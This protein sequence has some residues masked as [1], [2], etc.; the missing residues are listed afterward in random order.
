MRIVIVEDEILA[1]EDL[2]Q[3]LLQVLPQ[4]EIVKHVQSVEEGLVFFGS[5][6]KIDLIFSDIQLGDG[7]S[8]Q[9]FQEINI[10][11]PIVFCTAYDN[12]LLEAFKTNGIDY[13]VKPISN[14]A[15]EQTIQK[16]FGLQR[17]LT[18]VVSTMRIGTEGVYSA[19]LGQ[20]QTNNNALIVYHH[21]RI[22]P[23]SSG[24]IALCY[25]EYE[26][27]FV[28]TFEAKEYTVNKSLDDLEK[29]LGNVFFRA[30]R[31]NLVNRKALRHAS[32][33]LTRKLSLELCM[34]HEAKV[35][36]SREKASTFLRWLEAKDII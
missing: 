30:N 15:V 19:L 7:L 24:E 21:D 11:A 32:Y 35:Y 18:Q 8:F 23:L 3:T 26:N 13:I 27:V 36:V 31:Q 22:I 1:A 28:K 2:T 10:T 6:P 9:I 34:A 12:Y 5:D 4:S 33:T 16:Y 14:S 17:Q 29:L 20:M 25:I